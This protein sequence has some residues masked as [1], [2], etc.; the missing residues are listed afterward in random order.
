MKYYIE[1][2]TGE[3]YA[4]ESDGSQDDFIK[5]GLRLLSAK[6]WAKIQADREAADAPTPEQLLK[7]ANDKRDKFLA[8]ATLRIAP[9]QDAVDADI[10]TDDE[11]ASLKLWKL[12]RI[13]VN[14]INQQAGYPTSVKWPTPPG[15]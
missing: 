13:N 3:I 4:Y 1:P 6:E 9:L 2:E 11:I 15:E 12:Y 5:E 7:A 8:L 10:A 14:R